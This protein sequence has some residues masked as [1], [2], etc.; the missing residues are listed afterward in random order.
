MQSQLIKNVEPNGSKNGVLIWITGLSGVGKTTFLQLVN[1]ELRSRNYKTV[2]LDGDSLR[3]ILGVS[4]S[5]YSRQ[6]R[7]NL[8]YIYS[9]LCKNICDQGQIVIIATI[10]L[11]HEIQS[12]NRKTNKNYVEVFIDS[13]IKELINRDS[14]GVYSRIST[15]SEITGID[16]EAEFPQSPDIHV[17]GDIEEFKIKSRV[18]VNNLV[19]GTFS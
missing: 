3:E 2:A 13:P 19:N 12:F 6:E 4:D 7:L 10:A 11:F 5:C 14:K 16:F 8:A 15:S 9:R 1:A 18:L 17:S